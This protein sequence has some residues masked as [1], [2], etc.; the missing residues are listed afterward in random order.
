MSDKQQ[1]RLITGLKRIMWC[2]LAVSMSLIIVGMML[3]NSTGS[4]YLF[5][6]IGIAVASVVMAMVGVFIGLMERVAPIRE[7]ENV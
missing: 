7:S 4:Y 2:S 5:S 1:R 6:G 3:T